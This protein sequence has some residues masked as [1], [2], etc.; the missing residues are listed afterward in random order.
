MRV[1]PV[2][3]RVTAIRSSSHRLHSSPIICPAA[4]FLTSSVTEL[5][6]G[7]RGEAERKRFQIHLPD[8]R[9]AGR[10]EEA[11]EAV[12]VKNCRNRLFSRKPKHRCH[13]QVSEGPRYMAICGKLI[14]KINESV[15][16]LRKLYGL[17]PVSDLSDNCKLV[18]GPQRTGSG[19][20]SIAASCEV[21]RSETEIPLPGWRQAGK[22]AA[23]RNAV[24]TKPSYLCL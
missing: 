18:G 7:G 17:N 4:N 20:R 9:W 10:R 12:D 11:C 1:I 5:E 19:D 16:S 13:C 3:Y 6:I 8:T 14:G 21:I 15:G 22:A 23:P 24:S 2:Q